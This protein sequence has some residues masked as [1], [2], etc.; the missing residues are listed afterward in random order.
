[1][2]PRGRQ[3]AYMCGSHVW[4]A[5]DDPENKRLNVCSFA[6]YLEY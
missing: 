2:S 5:T 4:E 3:E 6:V 1:M